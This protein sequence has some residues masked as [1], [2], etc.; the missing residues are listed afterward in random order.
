LL[1]IIAIFLII[2]LLIS[3]SVAISPQRSFMYF[4]KS[5]IGKWYI[6]EIQPRFGN[7]RVEP[8]AL[9][10][11]QLRGWSESQRNAFA[12]WVIRI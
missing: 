1:I 3:I 10:E 9:W 5:S 2:I 7:V 11:L 12:L 6:K 8:K 4:L